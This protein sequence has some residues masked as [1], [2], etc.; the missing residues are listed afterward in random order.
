MHIKLVCPRHCP[1]LHA[2]N[3][4]AL[5]PLEEGPLRRL[6]LQQIGAHGH[7]TA[8]DVSSEA[9]ADAAEGEVPAL[10]E[11]GSEQAW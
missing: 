7:L 4:F 2:K 5:M 9:L 1:D 10:R 8:R 3:V 11:G 6:A